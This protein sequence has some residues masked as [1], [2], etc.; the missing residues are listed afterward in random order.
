MVKRKSKKL[1]EEFSNK[2]RDL[3]YK[4]C[5]KC[6]LE[7][8][9]SNFYPTH[10]DFLDSDGLFSVCRDCCTKIFVDSYEFTGS[11]EKTILFMCRI[12]NMKYDERAIHTSKMRLQSDRFSF[13]TFFGMY[14]A[15]LLAVNRESMRESPEG[16]DLTYKDNP[17][18]NATFEKIEDD[19]FVM[20]KEIKDF[21]GTDEKE[22]L[23]FLEREYANFKKNIK[24]TGHPGTVLLRLICLKMWDIEEARKNSGDVDGHTKHFVT[25]MDKMAISPH[26]TNASAVG[27]NAD[28][29]G[30]WIKEIEETTPAEYIQ[31]KSIYKDVDD[32]EVYA[33]KYITSPLRSFVSGNREF[34]INDE[35][36]QEDGG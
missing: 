19:D 23:E 36:V 18:V 12:F 13:D 33:E 26:L 9:K 11:V 25:L 17:I 22:K 34:S 32:I 7:R 30:T 14:K 31:D 20:A 4:V 5:R 29:F 6:T 3:N 15:S 28:T 2:D 35:E 27:K 16:V 24:E 10:D 8:H 21:W 1:I